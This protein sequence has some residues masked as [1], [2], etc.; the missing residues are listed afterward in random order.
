VSEEVVIVDEVMG[1]PMFVLRL[2]SCVALFDKEN[3]RGLRDRL[4]QWIGADNHTGS[5]GIEFPAGCDEPNLPYGTLLIDNENDIA[6]RVDNGW[7][8]VRLDGDPVKDPA[9]FN[10][11]D[12]TDSPNHRWFR[13]V[14]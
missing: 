7:K 9:T 11:Y 1:D 4:N 13:V 8:W 14:A 3:A 5:T 10:W 12:I 2:D 6:Q